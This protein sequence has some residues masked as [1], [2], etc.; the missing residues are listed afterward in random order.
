METAE[1]MVE[2]TQAEAFDYYFAYTEYSSSS[3]L[4]IDRKLQLQLQL[5][6]Q[7]LSTPC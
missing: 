1:H 4:P 2:G 5:V 7:N 3:G 6:E